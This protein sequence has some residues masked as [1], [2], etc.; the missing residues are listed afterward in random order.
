[1]NDQGALFDGAEELGQD[2]KRYRVVPEILAPSGPGWVCVRDI[3]TGRLHEWEV[4]SDIFG[5]RVRP[6]E[7]D[8]HEPSHRMSS[9]STKAKQILKNESIFRQKAREHYQDRGFHIYDVGTWKTWTTFNPRTRQ[10]EMACRRTDLYGLFDLEAW[11]GS[12]TVGVQFTSRANLGAHVTKM[13]D[14]KFVSKSDRT[15]HATYTRQWLEGGRTI[16]LLG[17]Y[18]EGGKGSHWRVEVRQLTLAVL[19]KHEPGHSKKR[20][21]A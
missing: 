21:V 12:E 9:D 14:H 2:G 1:M 15:W 3:E 19:E 18:Q 6:M 8:D 13:C 4:E 17:F 5:H 20:E 11:R 10:V 16:E 7:D